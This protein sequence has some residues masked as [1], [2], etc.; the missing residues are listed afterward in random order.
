MPRR[1]PVATAKLEAPTV[2]RPQTTHAQRMEYRI[3]RGE[4]GVLTFEPYK[5][6]L[7]PL[8]RFRTRGP[9]QQRGSFGQGGQ[10]R[11][12]SD[13][14]GYIGRDQTR[15][16]VLAAQGAVSERAQGIQEAKFMRPS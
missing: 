11:V 8:W 16:D 13:I 9:S 2:S 3:G 15:R 5:S 10:G 6:Y 7:L 4:M 12:Q 1:A 14:Q